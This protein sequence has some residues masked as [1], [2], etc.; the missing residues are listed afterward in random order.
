VFPTLRGCRR[1]IGA[2]SRTTYDP[3]TK[4]R[5][6]A[7]LLPEWLTQAARETSGYEVGTD[8]PILHPRLLEMLSKFAVVGPEG[9]EPSTYGLKVRSSTD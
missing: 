8:L 1:G 9:I 7:E 3:K 2:P 4:K 6:K 5:G